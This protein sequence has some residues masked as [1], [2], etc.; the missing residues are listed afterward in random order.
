M[1]MDDGEGD[2]MA[3][4]I[5]SPEAE[6]QGSVAYICRLYPFLPFNMHDSRCW[7]CR[8]ATVFWY[9]VNIDIGMQCGPEVSLNDDGFI[10]LWNNVI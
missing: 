6:S 5:G 10:L 3:C 4:S 1:M 9:N 2:R 8:L 7:H